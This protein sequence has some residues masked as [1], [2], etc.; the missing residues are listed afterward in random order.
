MAIFS[1]PV[2]VNGIASRKR[3]IVKETEPHGPAPLRVM[4]WR[5]HQSRAVANLTL[6]NGVNQISFH[7]QVDAVF[8]EWAHV[9]V[10]GSR[11]VLPQPAVAVI[12]P[13]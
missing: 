11:K 9:E 6:D 5:P 10:S 1:I 12:L 4:T 7:R 8:Q 3:Y 13:T 2:F